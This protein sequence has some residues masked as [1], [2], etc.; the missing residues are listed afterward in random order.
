MRWARGQLTN[1]ELDVEFL[2]WDIQRRIDTKMLPDGETVLCFI[3]SDL[4]QYRNWWLVI[5]EDKVDVCTENPGRDVDLYV[6]STLRNLVE[7]W[8]GDIDIALARRRKL[9]KTQGDRQLGKSLGDWLG[10]NPYADIRPGDP[11]LMKIAA[12]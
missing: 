2:M 5:G 12:D 3:F 1:D 8:E 7:I 9:L 6:T 4:E 11:E 10:I